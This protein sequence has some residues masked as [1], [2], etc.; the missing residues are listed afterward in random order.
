MSFA[1]FMRT[2]KNILIL[3]GF[4]ISTLCACKAAVRDANIAQFRVNSAAISGPSVFVVP[5]YKRILQQDV[6][7]AGSK[8]ADLSSAKNETTSFQII[9]AA[10]RPGSIP[11]VDL[12]VLAWKGPA[13]ANRFPNLVLF[14]EH[15]VKVARSSYEVKS[16][17]GMY[18]DALIPFVNPY[19]GQAITNAK[20]LARNQ[21]VAAGNVQ[22]Y[23]IDVEVAGDVAAGIYTTAIRVTSSG[24]KIAEVPVTLHVY[25][26]TLPQGPKL[27]A[28]FNPLRDISKSH[29]VASGSEASWQIVR[30]YQRMFYEN[31]V[32]PAI[33]K[34]PAI[35]DGKTG[36]VTFTADYVNFLRSFINEFGTMY[37][38]LPTLFLG[39]PQ[40]LENYLADYDAFSKANP[41]AGQF[42]YYIDEISTDEDYRKTKECGEILRQKAG[43]LK[44]FTVFDRMPDSGKPNVD[45]LVDIKI[46]F[47]GIAT[48]P[49]IARF[50]PSSKELW[51]Y[52]ALTHQNNP[53]WLLDADILDYRVVPWCCWRLGLTGVL[54]WQTA[55]WADTKNGF[56]PWTQAASLRRAGGLEWCGE[57]SLLY[58]GTDAGID[59]PIA[60]MRLKTFRDGAEDYKYLTLLDSLA[61]NAQTMTV[62]SPIVSD[63]QH[64]SKDPETYLAAR[65]QIAELIQAKLN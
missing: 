35:I 5:A 52:T 15:Y 64:Y 40:K 22:G 53:N 4:C 48:S 38:E 50:R 63:F 10:P 17:T 14:R 30:R 24:V 20:Y 1:S 45:D 28:Y 44:L 61:G 26:F 49:N 9:V 60:S 18:P 55:L 23:W 12:A 46:L 56:D 43:S 54:Y 16:K 32:C 2:H 57:G 59:G 6:E 11:N 29:N 7:S 47:F 37:I 62:V 39:E 3:I 36:K 27:K 25:N 8:E 33:Q 34:A 13:E 21:M 58:P 65:K 41:W 31:E 19:T 51:A 42:F